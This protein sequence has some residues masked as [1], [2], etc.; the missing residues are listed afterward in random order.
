MNL[1]RQIFAHLA[2]S[3]AIAMVSAMHSPDQFTP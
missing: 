2:I 1:S 3:Q